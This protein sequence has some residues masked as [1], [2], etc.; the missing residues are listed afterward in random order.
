MR[1]WPE[2]RVARSLRKMEAISPRFSAG[3]RGALSLS[4][5]V[6][7]VA[8]AI[9]GRLAL[10]RS[11]RARQALPASALRSLPS[12]SGA[13]A[14][15]AET[16]AADVLPPWL[17]A[18]SN[19]TFAWAALLAMRD[20]LEYDA[21][22][23]YA[24]SLLHDLGLCAPY[25]PPPGGCFA[26]SGARAAKERLRALGVEGDSVERLAS[27]IALHL[28]VAVALRHGAEAHLLNRGAALDVIG[29]DARTLERA[30]R[31]DVVARWPRRACKSELRA[32]M[33]AE[34]RRSPKSRMGLLV[35]LGFVGLISSAPFSE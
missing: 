17:A 23:L 10:L 33:L 9:G 3:D 1:H 2:R 22:L 26:L 19:R 30:L 27:A 28:E 14:R 24:A 32:A 11:P 5:R 15:H 8:R 35:R 34:A 7:F 4:A 25:A 21:E 13:L 18:H 16:I 29:R 31:E 6:A 12:P 20:G